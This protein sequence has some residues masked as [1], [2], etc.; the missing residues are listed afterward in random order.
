MNLK[1]L[2]LLTALALCGL[3]VPAGAQPYTLDGT[4][5][6]DDGDYLLTV[7]T[8]LKLSAE[9]Y[10]HAAEA[11]EGHVHVFINGSLMGPV[12]DG[13]PVILTRWRLHKGKNIIRLE[14]A[15]NDHD[16]Y[17]VT[18]ELTLDLPDAESP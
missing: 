2:A 7:T 17:G 15:R 13:D 1:P 16:V 5:T 6:E 9:H 4:I 8:N 14:L 3:T 10:G 12:T 18:R 11:G